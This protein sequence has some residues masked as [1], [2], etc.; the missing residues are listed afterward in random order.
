MKVF[1]SYITYSSLLLCNETLHHSSINQSILSLIAFVYFHLQSCVCE[2]QHGIKDS[3]EKFRKWVK[4]PRECYD[5]KK[6]Q[7]TANTHK[8]D[9]RGKPTMRSKVQELR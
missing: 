2:I 8:L 5:Q 7:Y 1:R 6:R 4:E 3:E 9:R